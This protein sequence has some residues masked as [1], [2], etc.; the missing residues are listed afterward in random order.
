[1][2][3]KVIEGRKIGRELGFPT[4]NLEFFKPDEMPEDGVYAV[5]VQ[6]G[7]ETFIGVLN[8]GTRPTFGVSERTAEVHILDFSREIYGETLEIAVK[9]FIRKEKTFDNLENLKKQIELDRNNARC[10]D[11]AQHPCGRGH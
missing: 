11:Y 6:F 3:A 10:F 2:L 5:D 4:A 1:M 8:V 7:N 9:K